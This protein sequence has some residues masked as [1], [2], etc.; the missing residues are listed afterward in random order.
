MF[1]KELGA[2]S[3]FIS[4]VI[5]SF[6]IISRGHSDLVLLYNLPYILFDVMAVPLPPG[7]VP[8]YLL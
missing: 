1:Q 6:C 7:H 5:V 8:R 2:P 3:L 4:P